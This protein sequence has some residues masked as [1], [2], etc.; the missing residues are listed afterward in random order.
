VQAT[1][2]KHK[3]SIANSPRVSPKAVEISWEAMHD[4]LVKLLNQ[5][6]PFYNLENFSRE[7]LLPAYSQATG[8]PAIHNNT[9]YGRLKNTPTQKDEKSP[10]FHE[11]APSSSTVSSKD[12]SFPQRKFD[13][14]LS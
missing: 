14:F 6:K 9:F 12:H 5:K 10:H 4:C 1:F 2:N 8:S 7:F 3:E 11:G 13:V